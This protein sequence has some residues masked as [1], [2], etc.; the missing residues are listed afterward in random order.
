LLSNAQ[1][2]ANVAD[3]LALCQKHFRLAEM[4]DDLLNGK[5]LPGHLI[6]LMKTIQMLKTSNSAHGSG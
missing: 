3:P 1:P 6:P 5:T 4:I 2:T